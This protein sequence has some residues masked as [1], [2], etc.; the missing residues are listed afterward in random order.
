MILICFTRCL[1]L[2]STQN[3]NE[4]TVG[5]QW[6]QWHP[7]HLNDGISIEA[8]THAF[9]RV[10]WSC[11]YQTKAWLTYLKCR[12]LSL[13]IMPRVDTQ[14]A[15]T[16][17][18][19]CVSLCQSR[20]PR[21]MLLSILFLMQ[22]LYC[23]SWFLTTLLKVRES[24]LTKPPLYCSCSHHSFYWLTKIHNPTLVHVASVHCNI[25]S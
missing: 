2:K 10:S 17:M 12:L 18:P 25:S 14:M 15:N 19:A 16:A 5:R 4:R 21:K 8:V 22:Q 20:K 13:Q 1:F 24:L 9:W 7:C 11:R 3:N 6:N 23:F